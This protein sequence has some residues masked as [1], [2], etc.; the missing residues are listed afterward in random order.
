MSKHG[1]TSTLSRAILLS[2]IHL[3]FF[4]CYTISNI[5]N[6]AIIDMQPTVVDIFAG[7]GGLSSG[8]HMAGWDVVAA[9]ENDRWCVETHRANFPSTWVIDGDVRNVDFTQFSGVDLIA[10][11]PPCQPFSVA[12]KQLAC[13]D[14]RDMIP[15]FI[16][17]IQE[18]RPKA[19]L[20]ENVAGLYSNRHRHILISA[21]ERL[22]SL[23]YSVDATPLD[24]AM[25][26]V[27]QRRERVFLVGVPKGKR[28]RFPQRSH[29]PRA[30]DPYAT[31]SQALAAAPADEP[32]RA[33]VT[34]AKSPILRPS[35]YAG[36]LVNGAGRPMNLFA[37]SPTIPAS[38]GGNRTHIVDEDGVLLDYHRYLLGG[39]EP[40]TGEVEGVRRLTLRESA[41]IQSF[42]PDYIFCGPRSRQ[43]SQ[44]GNAV[45][46]LLAKAVC[47]AIR[48]AL[49]PI[50]EKNSQE[51]SDFYLQLAARRAEY[52]TAGRQPHC[53]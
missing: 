17:A 39:G 14:P 53:E 20:M 16:R 29:G 47:A 1:L 35:P 12:G 42:P 48:S 10:G 11:G 2:V 18:A 38:A 27:P 45:P 21:R 49:F 40:R 6:G 22:Q 33:K 44:V 46:P 34:F 41:A 28:F 7:A 13:D 37:P 36:M 23:G 52:A 25:Y 8:L 5:A 50:Y 26:G 9:V 24:A 43:Y 19:F 31:V 15:Q 51:E 3:V 30:A 4:L 32:N